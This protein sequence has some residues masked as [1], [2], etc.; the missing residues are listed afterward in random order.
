M[1]VNKNPILLALLFALGLVGCL[2]PRRAEAQFIGYTSPQGVTVKVFN[3]V[4]TPQTAAITSNPGQTMHFLFY[5]V[6]SVGVTCDNISPFAIRLEASYDNTNWFAI[7]DDANNGC[8][9]EAVAIGYYPYLQANLITCQDGITACSDPG[10]QATVTAYYS[11]VSSVSGSPWGFYGASQQYR[12][13]LFAT[14]VAANANQTSTVT[15]TPYGST[16]GYLILRAYG[17]NFPANSFVQLYAP[18]KTGSSSQLLYQS[19]ATGTESIG[20][21]AI[22]IVPIRTTGAESI[23]LQYTSGGASTATFRA[24]FIFVPS[25]TQYHATE[26]PRN[27]LNQEVTAVNATATATLNTSG[28]ASRVH[29]YSVSARCSAGSAQLTVSD[30]GTQIWSS[31]ATEVGTTT[32]RFQWNPGLASSVSPGAQLVVSLST[33]G[34]ANTGTLDVQASAY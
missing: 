7:S 30:K 8:S 15:N 24:S 28:F 19:P 21:N 12:K 14:P 13:Y 3:A 10:I 1:A 31:G 17:G 9:G 5:T 18:T 2:A 34:A 22:A 11:G 32:F 25:N 16:S 23:Q 20:G 27:T 26:Q 6:N 4:N 33:C 29:L